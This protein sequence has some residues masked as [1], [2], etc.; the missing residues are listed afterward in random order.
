MS[1]FDGV[2]GS[3]VVLKLICLTL[4]GINLS[5]YN[6]ISDVH[7]HSKVNS[8]ELHDKNRRRAELR[9]RTFQRHAGFGRIPM[10]P[11]I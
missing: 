4:T 2:Y 1:V 8:D 3:P 6:K 9:N 7:S 5:Y 10:G 11:N